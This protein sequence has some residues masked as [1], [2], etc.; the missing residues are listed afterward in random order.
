LA[1]GATGNQRV[2][3]CSCPGGMLGRVLACMVNGFGEIH[4]NHSL[5]FIGRLLKRDTTEGLSV[6]SR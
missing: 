3:G 5:A 2:R 1:R 6:Y 4:F